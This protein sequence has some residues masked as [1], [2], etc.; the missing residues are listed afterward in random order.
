MTHPDL[1]KLEAALAYITGDDG[2]L[3]LS[4]THSYFHVG[5]L[6]EAAKS[7]LAAQRQG[8]DAAAAL[9][10]IEQFIREVD[11]AQSVGATWYTRGEQGLFGQIRTWREKANDAAKVIRALLSA[12]AGVPDGWVL[13]P[14]EPTLEMVRTLSNATLDMCE[15][16][17]LSKGSKRDPKYTDEHGQNY[18]ADAAGYTALLAPYINANDGR[19]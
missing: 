14:K 15:E 6:A 3:T 11:H 1:D 9:E 10:T 5:V 17:I 12:Q 19:D 7:H 4:K 18:T 16:L 13:V 8:G 2:K